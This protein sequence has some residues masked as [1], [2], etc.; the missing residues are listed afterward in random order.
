MTAY[1]CS[2]LTLDRRGALRYWADAV[3][4]AGPDG[5]ITYCGP[6][7]G[8]AARGARSV[9]RRGCVAIPGLVDAHCHLPQYPAVAAD[10]LT[11]LP[12]L[13]RH[14]FPLERSFKGPRTR[15]AARRFFADM[16]ASGTTS[17]CVY[18]SIWKEST[19]T[20]FEEADRSGLRI[21]MGKVMMDQGSYDRGFRGSP[22]ARRERSLAESDELCRRWHRRDRGRLLYAFTPR[23]ALSC[24]HELMRRASE[25]ASRHGAFVQ[26][27]LAE[28]A[29]ELRAVARAF[30]GAGS[31]TEVYR[32]AGLLGPRSIFAHAIWLSDAE[33][34]LLSEAGCSVAHCPTSNA[35]LGSG[36]MDLARVRRAGVTVALGTDVAAGPTLSVLEVMRQAVYLQ[37]A[38]AA[39]RL[40]KGEAAGPAEAFRLATVGGA[41]ALGLEDRIGT[42]E[43]GKEGDFV[44][45][46]RDSF[47]P[48]FCGT[49]EGETVLSRLVY[50]GG[51]A[52]E[53]YVRG[54]RVWPL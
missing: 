26:T 36:I 32:R 12:W 47:E 17:A 28:N 37:R 18:T 1:R 30:P 23:F 41:R 42:L 33:L 27:H 43:R 5:F 8:F 24:S 22:A 29:E 40:F 2:V 50:R 4:A 25:L 9:D 19:E 6:A 39:H 44:L 10:G 53:T 11:L 49:A 48:A 46:R 20:C 14:I 31:Y 35:F 54:K 7:K 15:E 34:R 38:A 16:A 21:V 45:F 3:L 51:P 13:E 52:H